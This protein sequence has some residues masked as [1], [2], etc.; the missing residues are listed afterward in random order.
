MRR[1][2]HS[3]QVWTSLAAGAAYWGVSPFL[4]ADQLI[5]ASTTALWIVSGAVGP[6]YAVKAVQAVRRSESVTVQHLTFGIALGWVAT[7]IWMTDRMLWLSSR[8]PDFLARNKLVAGAVFGA[9]VG[10]FYHLTSPGVFG[11]G[12][13]SFRSRAVICGIVL[14]IVVALSAIMVAAP[15]D[16]RWLAIALE[17]WLPR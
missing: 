14:F 11:Q 6:A 7:F 15:P 16:L 5:K 9:A 4:S 8:Y 13:R 1:I 17:P 12:L 10:C 3:S 2:V